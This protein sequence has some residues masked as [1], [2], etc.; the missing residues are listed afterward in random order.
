MRLDPEGFVV[1]GADLSVVE[2]FSFPD[3]APYPFETSARNVFA[4]G[5]VRSGSVKRVAAGVGEE[6]ACVQVIHRAL[7][8]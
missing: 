7:G 2:P 5:D 6:S 8:G 4:V 3:R 1:T